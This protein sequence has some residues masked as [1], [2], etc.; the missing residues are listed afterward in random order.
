MKA[1]NV[2]DHVSILI[3]IDEDYWKITQK[4]KDYGIDYDNYYFWPSAA[5]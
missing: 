5:R 1:E 3:K 4:L 2:Y